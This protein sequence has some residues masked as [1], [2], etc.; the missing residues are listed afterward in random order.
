MRPYRPTASFSALSNRCVNAYRGCPA[1][2]GAANFTLLSGYLKDLAI[3]AALPHVSSNKQQI[4]SNRSVVLQFVG[5]VCLLGA[6]SWQNKKFAHP[7]AAQAAKLE[8]DFQAA[9]PSFRAVTVFCEYRDHEPAAGH[10]ELT[11]SI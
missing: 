2:A 10:D 5:L 6:R 8:A 11:K 9:H 3:T 7:Y 4:A 1:R